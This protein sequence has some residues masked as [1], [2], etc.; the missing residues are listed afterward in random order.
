VFGGISFTREDLESPAVF[1]DM[2]DFILAQERPESPRPVGWVPSTQRWMVAGGQFVGRISLRHELTELLFT[3]GGHIGYSVRPSARG[4]G[5]ATEALRRMLPL[6]SERGLDQVLVT[7]DEGNLASR[8]VIETN[9]GVY[10]DS[11]EGK[12]RYWV[13]TTP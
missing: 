7:C 13:P 11:R 3:W 10:E 12:R 4:R 5:L 8:A 2:V 9:G 6:C 1:A